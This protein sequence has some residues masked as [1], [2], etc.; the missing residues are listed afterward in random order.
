[1]FHSHTLQDVEVLDDEPDV[2]RTRHCRP[3]KKAGKRE[4]VA[5]MLLVDNSSFISR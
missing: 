4:G 5:F 3:S 1:M 2:I